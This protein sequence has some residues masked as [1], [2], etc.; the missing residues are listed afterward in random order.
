[1]NNDQIAADQF[2]VL[3]HR[4][5]AQHRPMEFCDECPQPHTDRLLAERRAAR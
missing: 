5:L 3:A 4:A 2:V 1:M